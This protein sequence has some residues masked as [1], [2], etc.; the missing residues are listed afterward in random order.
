[1]DMILKHDDC[2]II[3]FYIIDVDFFSKYMIKLV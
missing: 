2:N 1:M 3:K